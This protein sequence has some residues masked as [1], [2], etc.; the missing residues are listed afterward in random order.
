MRVIVREVRVIDR[1]AQE[2]AQ[3]VRAAI[4]AAEAA[5]LAEADRMTGGQIQH[6]HRIAA[7]FRRGPNHR[8]LILRG[9]TVIGRGPQSNGAAS[10]RSQT[11]TAPRITSAAKMPSRGR[12]DSSSSRAAATKAMAEAAPADRGDREAI[13]AAPAPRQAGP[14]AAAPMKIQ[15]TARAGQSRGV[16][17]TQ[18]RRPQI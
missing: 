5:A 18:L 11:L 3:G 6:V 12:A 8:G 9:L 15:Q 4:V 17:Y 10:Q 14:T 7:D 16:S 2:I 1:E 13:T